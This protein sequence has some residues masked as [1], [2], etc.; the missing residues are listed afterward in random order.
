LQKFRSIQV[1]RGVA[2]CSVLVSHTYEPVRHAAYGAAGVDLFFVISG[3]IMANLAPGRTAGQFARDRIFRIYPMWWIAALPW[4]LLVWKGPFCVLSTLTLWPIYGDAHYLP[5]L[6]VGWTLCLEVLFYAGVTFA[7]ATRP[8]IALAAYALLLLGALT[9]SVALLHFVGSPMGLEFLMGVA[10]ARLPKRRIFGL[11]IL[12]GPALLALTPT[13]LGDL[14]SSLGPEWALR[15]ALEWGF[16]AALVVW[17]SLSLES[18]FEHR[19][20][21]VPVTIG[22][23][24]Y[25]IYLFHPLISYGFDMFW[26]VRL[27]LALGTGM[28]MYVLAE[29]QIMAARKRKGFRTHYEEQPSPA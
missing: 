28:A 9:T 15:R 13:V 8:A 1:L 22:D 5:V 23:A 20:F 18:L 17:G 25:S 7:I 14:G 11:F 12:L 6:K 27:A 29:R 16:P 3:F 26:A 21:N 4:L 2:A 24:S 10:V 19:L